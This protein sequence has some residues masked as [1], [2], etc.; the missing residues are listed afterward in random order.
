MVLICLRQ[1]LPDIL[2]VEGIVDVI[3][4]GRATGVDNDK[5][6][7]ILS[8]FDLFLESRDSSEIGY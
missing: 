4:D 1:N 6:S 2:P 5:G 3:P 8:L 7:I